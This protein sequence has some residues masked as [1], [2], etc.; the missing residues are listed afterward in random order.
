ML[1]NTLIHWA[2]QGRNGHFQFLDS[3]ASCFSGKK[4]MKF[5]GVLCPSGIPR[6]V[7]GSVGAGSDAKKG[8]C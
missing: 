5:P 4:Q 1:T 6:A 7:L 8:G 2:E 3:R